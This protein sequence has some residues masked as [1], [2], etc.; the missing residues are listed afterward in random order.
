MD[1]LAKGMDLKERIL[2]LLHRTNRAMTVAEIA[3]ECEKDEETIRTTVK[4]EIKKERWFTKVPDS[5][6]VYRIGLLDRR[7]I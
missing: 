5:T 6:G 1:S 4:R 2:H 3:D 7:T